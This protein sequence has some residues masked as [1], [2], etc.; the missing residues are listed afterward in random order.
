MYN[1]LYYTKG[2]TIMAYDGFVNYAIAHELSN[3]LIGGKINKVYQPNKD[4]LLF[5]IYANGQRY[6]LFVGINTNACRV[7]LTGEAAI[8]PATPYSFCMLLRKHLVGARV[9]EITTNGLDRVMHI[10][11]DSYNE[12]NDLSTKTIVIELMGRHSNVILVNDKNI[13]ID[14]MRHIASSDARTI[15]P[16]NPYEAIPAEKLDL[17]TVTKKEFISSLATIENL[18]EALPAKFL[19]MSKRYAQYLLGKLNIS[20]THVT[21]E[22]IETLYDEIQRI[23]SH[24]QT[25]NVCC[26]EIDTG[27]KK[28]YVLDC[29]KNGSNLEVNHFIDNFYT[30]KEKMENFENYRNNVL[31]VMLGILKKYTNRLKSIDRKLEECKQMD[32]YQL[33]G[34]LITSHLYQIDNSINVSSILLPNY[35][36][37]EDIIIP[38][39]NRYSPA[40]NAKLFFKKYNKLKTA[41]ELVTTQK[42]ETKRELQYIESIVYSLENASTLNEVDD[43]Y[44]EIKENLLHESHVKDRKKKKTSQPIT[45]Q[46]DNHTVYVGKNN[47]QN[48]E[49]TF[50]TASKN[51]IW[52]H[53]KDIHGSHVIL[54]N[55][56]NISDDIISKC[57]SLAAYYSK[58][59]DAAKVEVQYTPVKN[60]RKPKHSNPGFVVIS[61]YNSI[62]V[63]PLKFDF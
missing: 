60:L 48:D 27:S 59:K 26:I 7:N 54:K 22:E 6:H 30:Q 1:A 39:D 9:K 61:S 21:P 8:N 58:S 31:K 51:D 5:Q 18:E 3:T 12:M 20:P 55:D 17:L 53:A 13:I 52:F 29:D 15:L 49:L 19:G 43:I 34:E 56:G 23:L 2:D 46:I 44:L 47:K 10:T 25:G 16:A 14:S 33:Y 50:K 40:H 45:L 28:E 24:I 41:L 37:G 35:Y 63:K 11:V 32:Q 57:A 4:T 42:K 36:T 38:L 62:M